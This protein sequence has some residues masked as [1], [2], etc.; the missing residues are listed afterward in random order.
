MGEASEAALAAYCAMRLCALP[1]FP[2]L[3]NA[4]DELYTAGS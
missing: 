3:V 1:L 4:L 2:F